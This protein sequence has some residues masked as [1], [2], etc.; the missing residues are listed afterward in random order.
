MITSYKR[1]IPPLLALVAGVV[2]VLPAIIF[3]MPSNNDLANHYHFA[4]PFYDAMREGNLY[5]SWLASPN[6]GYGDAV[7]RFYPPALYYLMAAG[8]ALT[9]NWYAGSLLVVTVVSALG[10]GG[11]YLWARSYFPPHVSV[12]AAVFYALMPY[13]LA[14]FYQAAQLAEF[15]AGAALLFALAF[16]KRVCDNRRW[17]DVAGLAIAYAALILSHLPLAVFGSLTLLVYG[18]MNL[19][20]ADSLKILGR[21]TTAVMLGLAAS[22]FY[23]VTMISEMKWIVADGA[24]PDPLLDYRHNFVFSTLSPEHETIWWMGLLAF[25]TLAMGVPS[26]VV[27]IK[28]SMVEHRKEIIPIAALAFLSLL[29]STPLSRPLWAVIP[30]LN[31]TQHPFRWLAVVSAV[32]PVIMAASVPFW[33]AQMRQRKRAVALVAMGVV[34]IA[35]SFSV[36]QTVRGAT[37]LSRTSFE[38]MIAPLRESASIVQ[39]LPV[40]AASNA[41]ERPSYQKCVPPN[42]RSQ[43][44]AGNRTVTIA[45]WTD[46]HRT[47]SIDTGAA[48]EVRIA[49]FYYPHWHAMGNGRDLPTRADADGALLITIPAERV[50]VDLEFREPSRTKVSIASSIISW[51]LI[52]S[53]LIFGATKRRDHEPNAI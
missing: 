28:K 20:K 26:I 2:V 3:G 25:A 47:F 18:L 51:T 39:W 4:I 29:M 6:S 49:T 23:W 5:P 41:H 44:E 14:E 33:S 27:F 50:T 15:T 21:L 35:V 46:E 45:V 40:W 43:V 24:N 19:T 52:T 38:R 22:S 48:T 30:G 34:L 8:R 13:H 11:A 17:G 37:Y 12:W 31:K 32:V 16:M 36:S 7:V 10:S 1:L 9:G 42:N 53:L